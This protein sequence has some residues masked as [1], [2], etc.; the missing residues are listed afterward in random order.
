MIS[1]MNQKELDTIM[2]ELQVRVI[3]EKRTITADND[4]ILKRLEAM[5]DTDNHDSL[6]LAEGIFET[7]NNINNNISYIN[8]I[9]DTLATFAREYKL[10]LRKPFY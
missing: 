10:K 5:R 7:V 1:Q 9:K 3:L 6:T 4:S 8:R 2:N